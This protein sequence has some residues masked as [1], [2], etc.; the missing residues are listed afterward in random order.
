MNLFIMFIIK[1]VEIMNTWEVILPY[2]PDLTLLRDVLPRVLGVA[3]S[4][5]ILNST[6]TLQSEVCNIVQYTRNS[7]L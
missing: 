4:Y 2:G 3:H 6:Y 7:V 1:A 5:F